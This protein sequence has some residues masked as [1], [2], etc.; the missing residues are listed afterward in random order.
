MVES[1]VRALQSGSI[2]WVSAAESVFAHLIVME[3][4]LQEK[5]MFST[6]LGNLVFVINIFNNLNILLSKISLIHFLLQVF[7]VSFC[8]VRI[9]NISCWLCSVRMQI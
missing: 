9:P 5:V 3:K 7:C 4:Q 6:L 1:C 2:L 8:S